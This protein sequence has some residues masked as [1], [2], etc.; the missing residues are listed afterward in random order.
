M[1]VKKYT[2]FFPICRAV[3]SELLS[4]C[5]KLQVN[6][7]YFEARGDPVKN[8]N[9]FTFNRRNWNDQMLLK[10]VDR[11]QKREQKL[12]KKENLELIWNFSLLWINLKHVFFCR[13]V[14]H[15]SQVILKSIMTYVRLWVLGANN[16][17]VNVNFFLGECVDQMLSENLK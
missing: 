16:F 5:L 4:F 1:F 9:S 8:K 15:Y 10:M 2:I 12:K 17:S 6:A 7:V 3:I 14:T 11:W 13:K